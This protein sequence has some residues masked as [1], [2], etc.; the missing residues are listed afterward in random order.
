MSGIF[1]FIA[2][3]VVFVLGKFIYDTYLTDNTEKNWEKYR[4]TN[5][6]DA[7]KLDMQEARYNYR[8]TT[9]ERKPRMTGKMST[10]FPN[11]ITFFNEIKDE[12]NLEVSQNDDSTLEVR[13]PILTYGVIQGYTNFMIQIDFDNT[14]SEQYYI[15]YSVRSKHGNGFEGDWYHLPNGDMTEDQYMQFFEAALNEIPQN[16]LY[17]QIAT[18]QV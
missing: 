16:P 3:I 13:M 4:Q 18:G 9:K 5:P 14:E 12:L 2:L 6:E 7:S 1:T 10:I 8:E 15:Q 17:L 11:F